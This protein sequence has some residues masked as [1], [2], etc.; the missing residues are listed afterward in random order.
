[1]DCFV[2]KE[3][4]PEVKLV[5]KHFKN[6]HKLNA[7]SSFHCTYDGACGRKYYIFQH[8]LRHVK[9]HFAITSKSEKIGSSSVSHTTAPYDVQWEME[10]AEPSV[11]DCDRS[12]GNIETI[13]LPNDRCLS[14]FPPSSLTDSFA[15]SEPVVGNLREEGLNFT[16]GLHSKTNFSNNDVMLVQNLNQTLIKS[17]SNKFECF[18]N[19]NFDMDCEKRASLAGFLQE[20]GNSFDLCNNMSLLRKTLTGN[21]DLC[22]FEE[23]T[24][25]DEV[26]NVYSRGQVS[27]NTKETTGVLLPIAFQFRKVFEC[28]DL[29]L[30]TIIKMNKISRHS[31]SY[32]NFIQGQLWKEKSKFHSQ[33]GRIAIPFFLYIDEAEINN[34]LGSHPDP[35]VFLYY[36]F[37]VLDY[38][39]TDLACLF[40]GK[41]YK[42]FGNHKCLS[43]LVAEIKSLEENGIAIRTSEGI[44]TVYF[45]LGLVLGD[46]LGLNTVLGVSTFSA[47]YFCRFCKVIKDCTHTLANENAALLRNRQNYEIDVRLADP[48][49]TGIKELSVFHSINSFHV[50]NNFAVDVMH[51]IF[52]G[53]CHYNMSHIID[54]LVNVK[55]YFDLPRLNLRK[56]MFN[57]GPIEIGNVSN[58]I[59]LDHIKNSKFKMTAREMMSFVHLFPLMVGDL[60][61]TDDEVWRFFISF[62]ELIDLLM[63][64]DISHDMMF[65]IKVLVQKHLKDYVR[66]FEDT[67]KRKH[68]LLT[69]Y[70]SVIFQSGPPR[71]YWSFPF[72]KQHKEHKKYARNITSRKN[73]CVSIAKKFQLGFASSLRQFSI[74]LIKFESRAINTQHTDLINI[75]RD[76]INVNSN[77]KVFSECKYYGKDYKAGFYL[78]SLQN[79]VNNCE[80]IKLLQIQEIILF[81]CHVLPYVLCKRVAIETYSEHL[82]A[83]EVQNAISD[84]FCLL[85]IECFSGPPLNLHKLPN[86]KFFFRAKNYY[87]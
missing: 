52:E 87:K 29:L 20:I 43:R 13:D 53:I 21:D 41:D 44:K 1:M 50:T 12:A 9:T 8:F 27:I 18:A 31:C 14:D 78:T 51:D 81:E 25:N 46:N 66:L 72:E 79:C 59:K 68:H 34:P 32:T 35:I 70:Y 23:F 62:L 69:H 5:W 77:F 63:C 54:Y 3:F 2:C 85:S 64:F 75:F 83:Y 37:P 26:S 86:G 45:I 56:N 58:D 7:L 19:D 42:S 82:S 22:D 60:V 80:R 71:L 65:R 61:S 30:K 48:K 84:Q 55:N 36:S 10:S 24:I 47:N 40:S 38:S 33:A 73:I 15:Q 4:V 16:L 39:P 67:L 76:K 6:E 74:Q 57:Y 49:Q 28:D 11:H 17:L